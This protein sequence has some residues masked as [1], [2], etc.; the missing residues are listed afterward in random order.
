MTVPGY[1]I[2]LSLEKQ[3]GK[4]VLFQHKTLQTTASIVIYLATTTII[5]DVIIILFT[6][7]RLI[8]SPLQKSTRIMP[9]PDFS[10]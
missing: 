3:Y 7:Q 6:M 9:T 4:Y 1:H 10:I 8:R 2:E 5:N